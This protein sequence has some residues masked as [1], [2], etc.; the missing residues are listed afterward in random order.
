MEKKKMSSRSISLMGLLMAMQIVLTRFL[1]IQTPIVRIGF[2]FIPIVMM[3]MMFNPL[4]A[5]VGNLFADFIGIMLFGSSGPYFPGFS[6]TAFVS[7]AAYSVFFYKKE[8]SLLRIILACIAV[9]LLCDVFL[10]TLWLYMMAPASLAQ[11]PIRLGKSAIML[12]I[13]MI[14][15]YGISHNPVLINKMK[16]FS[17]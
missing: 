16:Q 12:P 6:L 8:M 5:G 3:G 17:K 13:K 1:S 11:F 4:I 10:N 7:G 2:A 9:T 14:I 15:I